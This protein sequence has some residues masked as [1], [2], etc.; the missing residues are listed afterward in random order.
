M[1]QVRTNPLKLSIFICLF[2]APELEVME[3]LA[4]QDFFQGRNI[5]DMSL[6]DFGDELRTRGDSISNRNR[7]WSVTNGK[8]DYIK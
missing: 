5:S 1:D 7:R 6:T 4:E 8:E 2:R 3:Y